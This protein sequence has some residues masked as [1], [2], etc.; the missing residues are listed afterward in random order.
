MAVSNHEGTVL[1]DFE[2]PRF[3]IARVTGTFVFVSL[4]VLIA[5]TAIPYGTAEVWWKAFFICAIF[6]LAIF[7]AIEGYLSHA[8]ITDGWSIILPVAALVLFSFLQTLSLGTLH[9]PSIASPASR[10]ISVDPYETRFFALQLAAVGLYGLFLFRYLTTARR[11]RI[12]INLL[13][14]IAVVSAIFGILRRTA[15]HNTGFGLPLLH[16]E[17]GYGQFINQNHFAYLMEM[18]LGLILGMVLGGGISREQVVA[19]LAALLPI[20]TALALCGSR[21]GLIAMLAEIV[22]AAFLL[23]GILQ[24]RQVGDSPS[25]LLGLLRSAPVRIGLFLILVCGVVFGTFYLGG[26]HLASRIEATRSDFSPGASDLREGVSRNEIWALTYKIIAAHPVLGVGMGAYWAAVPEFHD[27]AGTFT[28]QEAHGDY[29]ELLASGGLVGFAIGIW[30]LIAVVKKTKFTLQSPNRFRRAAC[31]GAA[32]AIA[33]VAVHS[34]VDFGL[35]M[36]VNALVFTTLIVIATS[37]QP[38]NKE[39]IR[40]S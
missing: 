36:I 25:R 3:R 11:L 5:F 33:G 28:P 13:I 2:S 17:Q 38:W 30:F 6:T 8:W 24:N 32:I 35:H 26:E 20:W 16:L 39:P 7:W 22:V 18:G 21:G 27:A 1:E 15:Q 40:E 14:A 34:L 37:E 23:S 19:Y 9:L 10:T 12:V 31:L 4:L 29:L